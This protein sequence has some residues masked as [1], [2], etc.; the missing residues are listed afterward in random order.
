[1]NEQ[2]EQSSLF[3]DDSYNQRLDLQDAINL[4]LQ[5]MSRDRLLEVLRLARRLMSEQVAMRHK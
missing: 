4:E 3:D 5:K 1:M 2:R